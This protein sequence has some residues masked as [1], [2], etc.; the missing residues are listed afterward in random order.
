MAAY[1]PQFSILALALLVVCCGACYG[2]GTGAVTE[3]DPGIAVGLEVNPKIRLDFY[4]GR[5]KSEEIEAAKDKIGVGVSFRMKPLFKRFLESVDSDK[6]HLLV[7]GTIYEYSIASEP[8][9]TTKE[10]KLMFDATLRYAFK[11]DLLLG[12]RNRLELRWVNGDYHFRYR[13]RPMLERP[14]RLWKRDVTPYIAAEAFWDQRYSKWNMFKGTAGVVVPL[15]RRTSLEFL[16]E[17]QHCI[18]CA[19][20]NTNIFGLTLNLALK[21]KKK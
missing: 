21:L 10:H 7:L 2:Q 19:D 18:T 5:E 12:V 17:R 16:Y 20:V 15:Y 9:A 13:N 8:G 6:Q 4:A 14:F 1:T 11:Y 3:I